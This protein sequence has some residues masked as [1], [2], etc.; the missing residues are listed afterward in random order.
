M[1]S[2][3]IGYTSRGRMND[4]IYSLVRTNN[5][6]LSEIQLQMSDKFRSV[7][8]SLLGG[9]AGISRKYELNI[10]STCIVDEEDAV[11]DLDPATDSEKESQS[12]KYRFSYHVSLPTHVNGLFGFTPFQAV[13]LK[14]QR[15]LHH[16]KLIDDNLVVNGLQ[17]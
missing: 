17:E 7:R 15:L 8:I 14:N 10:D 11:S 9:N 12:W 1:I 3:S 13:C 16:D 4:R 5:G 6:E 2:G